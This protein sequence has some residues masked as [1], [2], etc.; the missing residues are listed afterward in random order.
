MT[1]KKNPFAR[2]Q[3]ILNDLVAFNKEVVATIE[4]LDKRITWLER[5]NKE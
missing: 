2:L 1:E 5:N 4:D 3:E